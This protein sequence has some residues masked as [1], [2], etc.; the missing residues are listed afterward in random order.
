[1]F[2]ILQPDVFS[3]ETL[4][5][6]MVVLPPKIIHKIIKK[7]RKEGG[8]GIT[9]TFHYMKDVLEDEIELEIEAS[10]YY[11]V[12]TESYRLHYGQVREDKNLKA[13]TSSRKSSEESSVTKILKESAMKNPKKLALRNLKRYCQRISKKSQSREKCR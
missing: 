9:N 6:L 2:E 10:R 5:S 11:D 1:M 7:K 8:E 13:V 3:N 4:N 12:I